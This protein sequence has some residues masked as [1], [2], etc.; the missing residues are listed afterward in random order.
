M[1]SKKT[2]GN[3]V[4]AAMSLHFGTL[5]AVNGKN[6]AASLAWATLMRGTEE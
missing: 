4:S 1:L 5:D 3:T 6:T 2:R